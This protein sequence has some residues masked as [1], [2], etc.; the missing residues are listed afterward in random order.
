MNKKK[1]DNIVIGSGISSLGSI[2]ALVKKRKEV[3]LIDTSD[4]FYCYKKKTIFCE[5]SL[6]FPQIL[7]WKRLITK[8][9]LNIKSFGGHSNIWGGSSLKLSEN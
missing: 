1:Y 4:N 3:L 7:N 6:P 2:L 9:L 8:K 5:Q